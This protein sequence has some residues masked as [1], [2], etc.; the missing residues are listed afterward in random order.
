MVEKSY[1]INLQGK[2]FISFEGLLNAFHKNGG[3][4]IRT[5]IVRTDPLIVQATVSGSKGTFQG[6]GDA[7]KDNVNSMI[8]KHKIRMAETRA[9]ARALRWYTNIGMC[10]A[11]EMGGDVKEA[12]KPVG[13][14]ELNC[15][16]CGVLVTDVVADFS[17][18]VHNKVLCRACQKLQ[19]K[20]STVV[21]EKV[22]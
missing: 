9:I 8:L 17:K 22:V 4:E 14:S 1:I 10:S 20:E 2:E 5:E 13:K 3:N 16:S 18:R 12:V 21:E 6:L 15:T 19:G 11:E 7:D